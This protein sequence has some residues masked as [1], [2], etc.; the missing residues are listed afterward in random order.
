MK[1][2]KMNK[3]DSKP[4]GMDGENNYK[5]QEKLKHILLKLI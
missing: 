2:I 1:K 4:C 5:K 3:I